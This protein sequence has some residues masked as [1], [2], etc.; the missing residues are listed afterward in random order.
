MKN[1]LLQFSIAILVVLIFG[2]STSSD[3]NGNST[4]TVIPIVPTNLT[5]EIVNNQV[6]LNWNDSSTNESGFKIDRKEG[7]GS[8][9]INFASVATDI[10]TYTDAAVTAGSTYTYRVYSYNSVGPSLGYSN[11]IT[12][13]IPTAVTLATLTT[14]A[15]S[16]ITTTAAA[17]GGT[18][19]SDGGAPITARGIVWSNLPNPTIDLPTQT[20][21][22]SGI[23]TFPSTISG[24]N[25]NWDYHVRAYATNSAGTA[26]GNEITF[27]TLQN[28]TAINVPGPNVTD[29][30]GYVYQS[31]TICN[32]T[33]TKNNLNVSKYS[34]GTPIPQVTDPT[35]WANL[36]TGAW[37][38]YSNTTSNGTTF[39]KLYN[40]YAVVGIYDAASA[41]NPALRKKLAPTGWHVP[42]DGEWTQLTDCLGGE[43]I[44]GGK[45]KATGTSLCISPNLDATNASGITGLP[46]GW[47]HGNGTF[48]DV[49]GNGSWWG[50][51]ESD[52][53]DAWT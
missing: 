18:I 24:L 41:N 3:G 47:C 30:D 7:T 21:D 8:W 35:A 53:A 9:A 32:Q 49:G 51:S 23:G 52:T 50:S 15:V 48:Y 1:T 22:G 29:I 19:T 6:K 40:W 13:T 38:Y 14:T 16:G 10:E 44:A 42:T 11:P 37:C 45:M 27:T 43:S 12:V 17:T 39:G 28:S 26:Y 4:T 2:C 36:T 33:W 20:S 31:V 5:G 46:G 34:D 25:P